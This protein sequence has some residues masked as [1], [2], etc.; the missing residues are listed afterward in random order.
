MNESS[1][2][3]VCK[4]SKASFRRHVAIAKSMWIGSGSPVRNCL[5]KS[6]FH[7]VDIRFTFIHSILI[8]QNNRKTV[9]FSSVQTYKFLSTLSFVCSL[10]HYSA[11]WMINVNFHEEEDVTK[12]AM[13]RQLTAAQKREKKK[14]LMDDIASSSLI[15]W[16]WK[17]KKFDNN[18][19]R[20]NEEKKRIKITT[21]ARSQ[22]GKKNIDTFFMLLRYTH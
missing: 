14:N 17:G 21:T 15:T 8:I 7:L 12:S 20:M 4:F 10:S 2:E 5:R 13:I 1:Y 3:T 16:K 6:N 22:K 9:R 19:D 18:E 11:H